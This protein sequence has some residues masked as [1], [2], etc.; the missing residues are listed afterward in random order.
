MSFIQMTCFGNVGQDPKFRDVNGKEVTNFSLAVTVFRNGEKDTEWLQVTCWDERKNK[1]ISDYVK[2]GSKVMVQGTPSI[3]QWENK[4]GDI[5]AAFDLNISFG[6]LVLG[7]DGGG[8]GESR[9]S[10]RTST[11][12]S[13]AKSAKQKQQ[14]EAD[15]V[16]VDD[17]IPF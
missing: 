4:S 3:R 7:G 13:G 15:Q 5:Q 17:E 14:E 9:G 2:K 8:G 12:S 11:R 16:D 6:Q 10:S 1:I